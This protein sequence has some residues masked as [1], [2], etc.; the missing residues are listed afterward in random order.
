MPFTWKVVGNTGYDVEEISNPRAQDI[1]CPSCERLVRFVEKELV[2]NL[3]L[4]GVPLV[5]VEKG[6]RV[7][8]CPRCGVCIEPPPAEAD[9]ASEAADNPALAELMARAAKL[10]DEA[11][12]WTSRAQLAERQGETDLA[13]EA[14]QW[15]ARAERE[16]ARVR[17][18]IDEE[19][20]KAREE[21][22][23]GPAIVARAGGQ[24]VDTAAED[25]F[26][27]LK[28][29][30]GQKPATTDEANATTAA[31][32]PSAPSTPT[33]P[34]TPTPDASSATPP[35]ESAPQA[36]EVDTE[37]EFEALKARLRPRGEGE[38]SAP[39]PDE[40]EALK[41]EMANEHEPA[42]AVQADVPPA[43]REGPSTPAP[44]T[45]DDG[46]DPVAALKRKLRP[47]T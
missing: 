2:K 37:K 16:A 26:R 4:F 45:P 30:L 27:S 14:L 9:T 43:S 29:R 38:G 47:K 34:S 44:E 8:E 15:K 22:S 33:T 40:Y 7:F 42:E 35:T 5:G 36:T 12:L 23:A 10:D 19:R 18:S 31:P 25:E 13:A 20:R 32:T 28:K 24:V 17:A 6:R 3:R 11:W 21:G 1:V 46:D 39:N 41:R